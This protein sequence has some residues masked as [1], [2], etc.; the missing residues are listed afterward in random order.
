MNVQPQTHL[1][2]PRFTRLQAAIATTGVIA[3]A[4]VGTGVLAQAPATA[5]AAGVR[6]LPLTERVLPSSALPGFV[7]PAHPVAVRSALTWA[8]SVERAG[9]PTR[10][11]QRLRQIGFVGGVSEQLR[12][13]YPLAADAVSTVER[14]RSAGGASAELSYQSAKAATGGPGEQ[15]TALH[16]GMP[17]AVGWVAH[18]PQ[19]NAINVMFT[20]GSYVYVIGSACR[21]W[22]HRRPDPEA[23]HRRRAAPQPDGQW[24]RADEAHPCRPRSR[25]PPDSAS[26]GRCLC[27]DPTRAIRQSVGHD[28]NH[29]ACLN[30]P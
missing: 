8:T 17:G 5:Q 29:S 26:P 3:T 24:L 10:E 13:V 18:S 23:D 19:L 30:L 2:R 27:T 14:F 20:G 25:Q 6:P 28:P 12:G 1:F 21:A 16:T 22:D 15:V 7:V 4:A 9:T 11:A